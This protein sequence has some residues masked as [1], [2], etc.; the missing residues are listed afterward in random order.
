MQCLICYVSHFFFFAV[1]RL[2][3]STPCIANSAPP[4]T[5]LSLGLIILYIW[6][7]YIYVSIY[8]KDKEDEA[9]VTRHLQMMPENNHTC[10]L[11][12]SLAQHNL[13]HGQETNK[14]TTHTACTPHTTRCSTN[15]PSC[16]RRHLQERTKRLDRGQQ[17]AVSN[18]AAWRALV[19]Q[20]HRYRSRLDPARG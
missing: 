5:R 7:T 14:H 10:I 9:N 6:L 12:M 15:R 19:R 17:R 13:G 3:L 2:L 11:A 16:R 1:I 20:I 18:R 8:F 4:P